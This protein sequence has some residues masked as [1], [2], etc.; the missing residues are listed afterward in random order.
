MKL[1]AVCIHGENL[2]PRI[3]PVKLETIVANLKF[4]SDYISEIISHLH[5]GIEDADPEQIKA[6]CTWICKR[7]LRAGMVLVVSR[8]N[9][10][11]RDLYYCY[12][13]FAKFYP[14]QETTMR[15]AL[16][17]ALNPTESKEILLPFVKRLGDFLSR[18]ADIDR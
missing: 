5:E 11:S 6:Y 13:L 16:E 12:E 10:F 4:Q 15:Q 3:P 14:Q 7:F 18:E 2:I 17:Y 1:N 8:A 9:V